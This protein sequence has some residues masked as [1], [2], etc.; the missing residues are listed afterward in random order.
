M[1]DLQTLLRELVSEILEEGIA[2]G[3]QTQTPDPKPAEQPSNGDVMMQGLL[4]ERMIKRHASAGRTNL[5]I[6]P[7]VVVTPLAKEAAHFMGI[8]LQQLDRR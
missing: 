5:G 4:T 2:N 8:T 3:P 6:G 7:K 1:T